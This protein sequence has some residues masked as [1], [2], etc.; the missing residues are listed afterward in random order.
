MNDCIPEHDPCEDCAG[1]EENHKW[2]RKSPEAKSGCRKCV[3]NPVCELWRRE[4]CQ[5]ASS[6]S[7]SS[8]CDYYAECGATPESA[9]AREATKDAE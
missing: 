6:Y 1:T 8:G 2:Y 4:E 3:H 9:L 7:E 5:D